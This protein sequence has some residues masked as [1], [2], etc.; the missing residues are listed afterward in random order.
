MTIGTLLG[1]GRPNTERMFGEDINVPCK[2][3]TPDYLHDAFSPLFG[4]DESFYYLD[5]TDRSELKRKVGEM[6]GHRRYR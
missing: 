6:L 5:M 1:L 3:R 4:Q 2:T